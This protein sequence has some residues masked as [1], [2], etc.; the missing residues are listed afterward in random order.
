MAYTLSTQFSGA[1]R[2]QNQGDLG[3]QKAP[4]DARSR[5]RDSHLPVGENKAPAVPISAAGAASA[6]LG[7]LDLKA[8]HLPHDLRATTLR[9]LDALCSLALIFTD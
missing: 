5:L 9:T 8:R 6:L 2:G 7:G 1:E 4:H 3:E